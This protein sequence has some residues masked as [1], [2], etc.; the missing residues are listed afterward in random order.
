MFKKLYI[1]LIN[2]RAVEI[3]PRIIIEDIKYHNSEDEEIE[4]DEMLQ[5]EARYQVT[6]EDANVIILLL[7][8]PD[9]IE[10]DILSLPEEI[11]QDDII[12]INKISQDDDMNI[13]EIS[14]DDVLSE[15][16]YEKL[17]KENYLEN[18]RYFDQIDLDISHI[19]KILVFYK[20]K[21]ENCLNEFECRKAYEMITQK[22]PKIIT[23]CSI[24]FQSFFVELSIMLIYKDVRII[25]FMAFL[26]SCYYDTCDS[27][28][29]IYSSKEE[30]KNLQ[31]KLKILCDIY[32]SFFK[33]NNQVA[34]KNEHKYFFLLIYYKYN[35]KIPK[36][37]YYIYHYK[38]YNFFRNSF[39][40]LSDYRLLYSLI[41]EHENIDIL[42]L[43]SYV[44][45]EEL[46]GS[47]LKKFSIDDSNE[48]W[49]KLKKYAKDKTTLKESLL[50]EFGE[51]YEDISDEDFYF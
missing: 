36:D 50:I 33:I 1:L 47:E 23:D 42:W 10:D 46:T 19:E 20:M 27:I 31:P 24:N 35:L 45:F 26:I 12:Y 7:N 14:R 32:D 16:D 37:Y 5:D 3:N 4:A 13:N 30:F 18:P 44:Y 2:I 21:K 39:S 38:C 40:S 25:Y 29:L 6:R 41:I 15:K 48:N 9:P 8:I 11:S 17:M 43:F 28:D 22:F 49:Q 34:E 51:N